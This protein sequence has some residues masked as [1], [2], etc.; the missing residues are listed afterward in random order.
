MSILL[1]GHR[2]WAGRLETPESPAVAD[3]D[4][5][6]IRD[7]VQGYDIGEMF[8]VEFHVD[9]H[10]DAIQRAYEIY[11]AADEAELIDEVEGFEPA[12]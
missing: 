8:A 3:G 4:Q 5:D 2:T 12:T 10:K 1:T 11:V 7:L 9:S 6:A